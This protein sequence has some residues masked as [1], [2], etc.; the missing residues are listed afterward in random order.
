VSVREALQVLI[1]EGLVVKR[2][3][4]ATYV[5][6][7]SSRRLKEIIHVRLL[8]EPEAAW[9]ARQRLDANSIRELTR[10]VA[11][12]QTHA[13]NSDV[14]LSS[15]ADFQFH[16]ALWELSGNEILARQLTQI[17]T[18]YFAYTSI[19]PGLSKTELDAQFG[20]HEALQ[21]LW[22]SGWQDRSSRHAALLETVIHGDRSSIDAAIQDHIYGGWRWLF[23]D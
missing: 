19:L 15:R 20:S 23:Q 4:T 13:G 6:E 17:C 1:H 22:Q 8:L 11:A 5:T 14:Y 3:N 10:L 16:R 9:L 18:A 2:E 7:L 12:I 21:R